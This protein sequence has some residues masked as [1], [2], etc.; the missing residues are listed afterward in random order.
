MFHT[1]LDDL[2]AIVEVFELCHDCL[3]YGQDE[4]VHL[5]LV[6]LFDEVLFAVFTAAAGHCSG[7][8]YLSMCKHRAVRM[9][10]LRGIY[11]GALGM[12]TYEP[13]Q[14]AASSSAL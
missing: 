14:T 5:G 7:S 8:F 10:M 2:A 1:F 13:E 9:R 3:S 4:E 6:L 11:I 12:A